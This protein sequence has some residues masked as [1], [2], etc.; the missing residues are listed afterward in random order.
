MVQHPPMTPALII[1]ST[2]PTHTAPPIQIQVNGVKLKEVQHFVYLGGTMSNDGLL[3]KE[4]SMRCQKAFVSFG[5]LW[6]NVF[7]RRDI[8]MKVKLQ[9]YKSTVLATLL[10]G[11]E[12]W[13]TKQKHFQKLD[14]VQYSCLRKMLNIH[15]TDC[16]TNVEVLGLA[17]CERVETLIRARRLQ[18]LGHVARM[19]PERIPHQLL[20]GELDSGSR[21]AHGQRLRWK[22]CVKRDFE[23]FGLK[24]QPGARRVESW[25][26]YVQN[27]AVWQ[28]LVS[29]GKARHSQR[30]DDTAQARRAKR[31]AQPSYARRAAGQI[32]RV[33]AARDAIERQRTDQQSMRNLRTYGSVR[34]A[35]R[36][37]LIPP[38]VTAPSAPTIARQESLV[39]SPTPTPVTPLSG[40]VMPRRSLR[41]KNMVT[42]GTG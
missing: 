19:G 18:W 28:R 39:A 16:V 35:K 21:P 5:K 20:F 3:D 42:F 36:A 41:I 31:H 29:A 17:G 15:W 27:R 26:P 2:P 38:P 25:L 23:E 12:T 7:G 13:V 8:K 14:A 4:I 1:P 32:Q 22:D 24:F 34:I 33:M 11:C 37:K 10:Y 6:H 9:L 40:D 30:A